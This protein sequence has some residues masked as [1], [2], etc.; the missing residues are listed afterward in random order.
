MDAKRGTSLVGPSIQW[1][2]NG[3]RL[4]VELFIY[5]TKLAPVFCQNWSKET[6]LLFSTDHGYLTSLF[7]SMIRKIPASPTSD[8]GPNATPMVRSGAITS[9]VDGRRELNQSRRTYERGH[10]P[11][12]SS[13]TY[14]MAFCL[15]LAFVETKLKTPLNFYAATECRKVCIRP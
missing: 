2:L 12:V 7:H 8:K 11:S 14:G 15:W 6:I 9:D 13:W 1:T 4:F 3:T 10:T 5:H